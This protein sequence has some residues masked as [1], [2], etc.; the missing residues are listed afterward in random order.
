MT[1]ARRVMILGAGG[2]LLIGNVGAQQPKYRW[3]AMRIGQC[4]DCV[5]VERVDGGDDLP[6][7]TEFARAMRA[8]RFEGSRVVPNDEMRS[9]L[10]G[11]VRR[12][13]VPSVR[14]HPV[15]DRGKKPD[16]DALALGRARAQSLRALLIQTGWPADRVRLT[17]RG[18]G[19]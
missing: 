12:G 18:S 5:A 11:M 2:L 6:Q 16:A 15:I 14:I 10:A 7:I 13:T 1:P 8:A 19:K 4:N 3:A 17:D 9:T